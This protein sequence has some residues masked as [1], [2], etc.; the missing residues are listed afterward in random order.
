[1]DYAEMLRKTLTDQD[2]QDIYR[3]AISQARL[4][5]A[6]ARNWLFSFLMS[7]VPRTIKVEQEAETDS[8]KAIDAIIENLPD[9]HLAAFEIA[10]A[11]ARSS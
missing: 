9:E 6:R 4:G 11:K 3:K 2:A 8:R 5:D 7:P 10:M 1:M